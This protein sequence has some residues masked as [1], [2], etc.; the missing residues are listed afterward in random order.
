M[1]TRVFDCPGS[2]GA[3][4]AFLNIERDTTPIQSSAVRI[5]GNASRTVHDRRRTPS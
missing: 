4:A 1:V 5:D 3:V 2:A